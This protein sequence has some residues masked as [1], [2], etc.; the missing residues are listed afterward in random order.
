MAKVDWDH[1]HRRLKQG[2][3]RPPVEHKITDLTAELTEMLGSP[4]PYLRDELAFELL[5]TWIN[6]GIY[7]DLLPGLGDG[8]ATG[9]MTGLGE[10]DTDSVFRRSYSALILAECV[11]RDT[12]RALVAPTKVLYWAD[13]I[14]T[15][16]IAE[17]DLRGFVPDKGWAHAVAHG[18]DAIGTL[19]RSRHIRAAELAVL[20]EVLGERATRPT[21]TVWTGGEG[22]K[23]ALATIA[24]LHRGLVTLDQVEEWLA[25]VTATAL[26]EEPASLSGPGSAARTN[27]IGFLRALYLHL[28][29]GRN[30]P[31]GRTDV[32][33]TVVE[34]LRTAQ[35][36]FFG[37]R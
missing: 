33:L 8:I 34:R 14:A 31:P 27:T 35:P 3:A 4:D 7:D 1:L 26:A 28:S 22:D 19:A 20:L 25:E 10:R 13:R 15:W 17:R 24:I 9:L 37:R 5:S 11:D 18:A 23:L 16:F 12:Q 6:S 32:L 30:Q 2:D 21:D 36:G 29:L